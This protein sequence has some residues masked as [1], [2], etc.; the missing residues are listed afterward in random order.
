MYSYILLRVIRV[1]SHVHAFVCMC[2][3]VCMCGQCA[4]AKRMVRIVKQVYIH[5]YIHACMCVYV[6]AYMYARVI[7]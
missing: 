1:S 6:C 7:I 3:C 4:V 5:I 2:V